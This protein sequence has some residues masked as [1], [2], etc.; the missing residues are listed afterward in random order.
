[1]LAFAFSF[2]S[3]M[4][5]RH[6]A[7]DDTYFFA[8]TLRQAILTPAAAFIFF[9]FADFSLLLLRFSLTIDAADYATF[10]CHFF[11]FDV[12]AFFFLSS[13]LIAAAFLFLFF[14]LMLRHTLFRATLI[15]FCLLRHLPPLYRRVHGTLLFDMIFVYM[16]HVATSHTLLSM[17]NSHFQFMMLHFLS[18]ITPAAAIAFLRH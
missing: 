5:L 14:S 2:F 8:A 13:P 15:F 17:K 1:M 6:Y 12:Y 11:V 7:A 18:F 10:I 16:P 4:L 3:C 9:A